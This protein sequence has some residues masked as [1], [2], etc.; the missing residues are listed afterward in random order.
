[1]WHQNQ[2][3]E[4]SGIRLLPY[5]VFTKLENQKIETRGIRLLAGSEGR[6]GD[7]SRPSDPTRSRNLW[8]QFIWFSSF[9]KPPKAGA[10]TWGFNLFDF[11]V[12]WNHLRFQVFMSKHPWNH[13]KFPNNSMKPGH[14][15]K[16]RGFLI[17]TAFSH[18][19]FLGLH[20]HLFG[21]KQYIGICLSVAGRFIKHL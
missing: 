18:V 3:I 11:G 8:F 19:C 9:V 20:L 15:K 17:K 5:V 14:K 6:S 13:T 2:K 12:T 4:T 21:R 10:E 7:S 16:M 1:M